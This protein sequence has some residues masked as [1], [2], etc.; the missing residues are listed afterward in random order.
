MHARRRYAALCCALM[1]TSG[2]ASSS[3][4]R[5][6]ETTQSEITRNPCVRLGPCDSWRTRRDS[7]PRLLPPEG[8][9]RNHESEVIPLFPERSE[10][11]EVPIGAGGGSKAQ[12]NPARCR[13]DSDGQAL[14]VALWRAIKVV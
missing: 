3:K 11:G 13:V 6:A 10:S 12:S 7:N 8:M 1:V 5:Q 2:C 9:G 4:T 14:V